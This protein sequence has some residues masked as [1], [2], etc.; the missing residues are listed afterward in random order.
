VVVVATRPPPP[1]AY[2]PPAATQDL[3][4]EL[5]RSP[6]RFTLGPAAL[7]TGSSLGLGLGASLDLGT[8]SIGGRISG[9]WLRGEERGDRAASGDM[10]SQYLGEVTIDLHKRGPF[11]PVFALGFGLINIRRGDTGGF[12]GAGTAR[13]GLEYA[14]G[15]EDA[16][17]RVGMSVLGGL[18]GPQTQELR[19]LRGYGMM[20]AHV[21]VGF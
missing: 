14:L 7:S 20:T 13:A 12:A 17:V 4:P 5:R 1:D 3:R 10:F 2:E 9:V 19:D 15:L 8:G 18:V 11:H 6:V 21:A 16:D